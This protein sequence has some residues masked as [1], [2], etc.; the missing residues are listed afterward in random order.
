MC[1]RLPLYIWPESLEWVVGQAPYG[2]S[3]YVA[4]A[5]PIGEELLADERLDAIEV[6]PSDSAEFDI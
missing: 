3:V 4:C 2:S 5:Q 6:Q 1:P